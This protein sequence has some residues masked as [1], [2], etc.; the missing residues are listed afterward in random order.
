MHVCLDFFFFLA[1]FLL[2]AEVGWKILD[3]FRQKSEKLKMIVD[4]AEE[5]STIAR[6]LVRKFYFMRTRAGGGLDHNEC[7][8][9][10]LVFL[11]MSRVSVSLLSAAV[12][13]SSPRE[14]N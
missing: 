3:I 4:F 1:N 13:S 6:K 14:R 8:K 9:R 12:S 2:L 10:F 11:E 7:K 5:H